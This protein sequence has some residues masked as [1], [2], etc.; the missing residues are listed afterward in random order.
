[1]QKDV[2]NIVYTKQFIDKFK[3]SLIKT[4]NY[5][6]Y[7]DFIIIPF[8]WK[9][10]L[11]YIP[12]LSYTDKTINEVQELL[13]LAK[14][15]NYQIRILNFDY[16]K[17]Q[18]DDQVTMR[19]DIE[20]KTFDEIFYQNFSSRTRRKIRKA[21]KY[22]FTFKKGNDKQL[23]NHFYQI[24]SQTM[25]NHGTPVLD[26]NLFYNLVNEFGNKIIFFNFYDKYKIIASAS[27]LIDKEIMIGE[28]LG[29]DEDYKNTNIGY[30][31]FSEIIK[32]SISES[33][34][35]IDFGRSPYG[36]GTYHFKQLFG[37]Y[38]VKIDILKPHQ[39]NIYSKYKLASTIWEKLPKPIADYC[40]SKLSKYLVDL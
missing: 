29:I 38:P 15:N 24:Y 36:G 9:K 2:N 8:L 14:N 26:I 3:K 33:K 22:N 31:M 40:G 34:K 25:L 12:L 20:N 6:V 16:K 19:M 18:K 5:D 23:I 28:W 4:Y 27:I 7:M 21:Q 10:T 11:M 30:L 35:I 39:E 17:F 32:Y 13:E 1:M 37:T